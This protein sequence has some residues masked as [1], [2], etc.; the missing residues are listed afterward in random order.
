MHRSGR[1]AHSEALSAL[2]RMHSVSTAEDAATTVALATTL[3]FA[4]SPDA[5]RDRIALYLLLTLLSFAVALAFIG[6]ITDRFDVGSPNAV[7]F[8]GRGRAACAGLLALSPLGPILY[9]ASFAVLV[10]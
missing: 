10:L 7:A 9:P 1:A 6:R 8:T 3:F 2:T 4:V 5:A